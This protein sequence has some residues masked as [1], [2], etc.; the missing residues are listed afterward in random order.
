VT[1]D[2]EAV[3]V[4]VANTASYGGGLRIAP[5]AD[6]HDGLLDVVIGGRFTRTGLI[7]ILPRVRRGTHLGHPLVT[8]YRAASVTLDADGITAYADGERVGPLPVEVSAAPGAL[9]VLG[10]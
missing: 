4:V 9:T 3:L 6:P 5:P 7:R 2:V 8:A 1:H 10:A